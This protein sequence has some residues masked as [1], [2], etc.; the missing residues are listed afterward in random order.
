MRGTFTG[1][2][3]VCEKVTSKL[4]DELL[5]ATFC[6]TMLSSSSFSLSEGKRR[7]KENSTQVIRLYLI[8]CI[9]FKNSI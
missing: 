8:N 9:G 6:M 5:Y 7:Q 2:I 3:A 1:D 4:Y